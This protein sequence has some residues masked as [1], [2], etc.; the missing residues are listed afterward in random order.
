MNTQPLVSAI[1]P[2]YNRAHI[3]CEAIDSI[4]AQT[5]PN[6]ETVVVDDGST[7]DT[8]EQLKKYG[9]RIRII[10][11]KNAGPAIAR[12]RGVAE[13]TGELI[14]FLDSDDIWLP[15]KLE[16]QV[17]LMNKAGESVPCCLCNILMKWRDREF[18]S[19]EKAWLRPKEPEGIWVNVDEVL[20]TRFVLFNQAVVIRREA[21]LKTGGFDGSLRFMEDYDLPLRLSLIGPWAYIA[22]PL[23]IWREMQVSWYKQSQREDLH[24]KI[25]TVEVF[26]RLSKEVR[27][28]P[29]G[30]RLRRCVAWELKR[31]RRQVLVARMGQGGG[32][33]AATIIGSLLGTIER[34]RQGVYRRSPW[35]PKM[36]TR[37]A[38]QA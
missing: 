34:V 13:S 32:S 33:W 18:A 31:A 7:D 38:N 21:L 6:I 37:S 4:L 10:S 29:G 15:S 30:K 24:Q 27:E 8:L 25:C 35:F 1:I 28:K 12:N 23:V 19:F 20:A 36:K 14:A 2:T 5:Y 22:E 3:V 9:K 26:E 17:A 11:Q 16:R